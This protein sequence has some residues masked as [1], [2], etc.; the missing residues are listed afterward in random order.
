MHVI[1]KLSAT[2]VPDTDGTY[3]IGSNTFEYRN[4]YA[5]KVYVLATTV[6]TINGATGGTITGA[7]TVRGD[8]TAS[9]TLGGT[10]DLSS[11]SIGTLSDVDITGIQNTHALKWVSANSNL[12]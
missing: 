4:I 6:E 3:D 8:I 12:K 11:S 10:F 2:N 1:S 7:L 9:G 5:R